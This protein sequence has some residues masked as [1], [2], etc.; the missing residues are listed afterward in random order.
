MMMMASILR[1]RRGHALRTVVHNGMQRAWTSS[2]AKWRSAGDG[3]VALAK[4][5]LDLQSMPL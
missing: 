2:V 3:M 4:Y 1:S 5:F